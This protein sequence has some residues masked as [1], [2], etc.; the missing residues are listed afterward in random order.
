MNPKDMTEEQISL[1][2]KEL[3]KERAEL[4]AML[5]EIASR[6]RQLLA[7]AGIRIAIEYIR[8]HAEDPKAYPMPDSNTKPS[9]TGWIA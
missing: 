9:A 6:K 8:L 3:D 5:G 1:E 2:L 4:E 7:E